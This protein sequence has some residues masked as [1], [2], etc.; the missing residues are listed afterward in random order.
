MKDIETRDDIEFLVKRFYEQVLHDPLIGHFFTE[1]VALDWETH[2]PLICDFW[3]SNLLDAR[4]YRGN[5]MLKHLAL[6]AKSPLE[7]G[8]FARWLLKWEE[9]VRDLFS[10][11][12]ADEA[13]GKAQLIAGLMK[14]K[15]G[16]Q[17]LMSD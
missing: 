15:I 8:H 6:N 2:I 14:Y 10:G 16:Q 1:V 3:A 11:P 17:D 9:T 7:P 5:P 4:K 13:V 12:I